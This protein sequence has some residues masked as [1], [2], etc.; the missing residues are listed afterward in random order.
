MR[1]SLKSLFRAAEEARLP[2]RL[3]PDL[4]GALRE[5]TTR[6]SHCF[7]QLKS[8]ESSTNLFTSQE[9]Q[10]LVLQ[11]LQGMRASPT[12]VE[13]LQGRAAVDE[14]QS[15]VAAWQETGLITQIFP[16]H[17]TKTLTQ[18]QRSW[19]KQI[20]APQPLGKC[21]KYDTNAT[22]KTLKCS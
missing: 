9:R 16:L 10:W 18:L 15:I 8:D 5:F 3:R 22:I 21:F 4:G 1:S 17:E 7:Q 20:F 11:V 2:K 13:A 14:G 6:E 12:D 19:V